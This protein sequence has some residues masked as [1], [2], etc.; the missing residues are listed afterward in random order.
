MKLKAFLRIL[1]WTVATISAGLAL[2]CGILISKAPLS[3]SPE[4]FA[5][6]GHRDSV[7][8]ISWSP[9]AEPWP[10]EE[11]TTRS[12]CGMPRTDNRCVPSAETPAMFKPS[13]G[14]PDC[15]TLASGDA[16]GHTIKLWMAGADN[17]CASPGDTPVS[18]IGTTY[19]MTSGITLE[20]SA[21]TLGFCT[22]S[23]RFLS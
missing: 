18:S 9:D 15:R 10:V 5:Q 21:W 19:L 2:T 12:S 3:K 13:P 22:P 14:S 6:L 7:N 20:E 23:M 11:G 4:I 1:V 16:Q 8:S 17:Y